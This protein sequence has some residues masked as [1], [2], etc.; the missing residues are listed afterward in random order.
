[1]KLAIFVAVLAGL[2]APLLADEHYGSL[3]MRE[4]LDQCEAAVKEDPSGNVAKGA[5]EALL[6]REGV[7]F[8]LRDSSRGMACLEEIYGEEFAFDPPSGRFM[9]MSETIPVEGARPERPNPGKMYERRLRAACYGKLA[10]DEFA[11]LTEPLCAKIFKSE[12]LSDE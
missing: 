2:P 9:R 8:N 11:A 6:D 4:L 5:G 1:M 12:G 7:I 10:E 3:P